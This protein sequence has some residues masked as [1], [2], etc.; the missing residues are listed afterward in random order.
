MKHERLVKALEKS[1]YEVKQ[2]KFESRGYYTESPNR[3]VSW[4]KQDDSA[5]C[6]KTRRPDDKDDAMS[7]Y[8]AGYFCHTIKEAVQSLGA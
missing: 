5:V 8:A 2:W 4:F 1:G 6:V 3:I 7:D